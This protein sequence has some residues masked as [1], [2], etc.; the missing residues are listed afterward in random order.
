MTALRNMLCYRI[1]VASRRAIATEQLFNLFAYEG[2]E[3]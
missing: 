1:Y 3:R 2:D